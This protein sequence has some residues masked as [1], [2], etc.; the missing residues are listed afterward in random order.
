MQRN[1]S[2]GYQNDR[3]QKYYNEGYKMLGKLRE[4][5]QSPVVKAKIFNKEAVIIYGEE[6]AK[7]FMIQEISNEKV[8]C[9]KWSKNIV[10]KGRC[11]VFRWRGTSSP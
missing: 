7:R 1:S 5:A 9:L 2:G 8:Q 10:W 6:A 3:N 4:E 11:A